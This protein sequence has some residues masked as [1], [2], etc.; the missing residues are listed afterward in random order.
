MSE[1]L[2]KNREHVALLQDIKIDKNLPKYKAIEQTAHESKEEDF[3][4]DGSLHPIIDSS[5]NFVSW[6][7]KREVDK[8][9]YEELVEFLS[10]KDFNIDEFTFFVEKTN[11]RLH[12][13]LFGI[14]NPL[15]SNMVSGNTDV[16]ISNSGNKSK[17]LHSFIE[18]IKKYFASTSRKK[19]EGD[20]FDVVG[21]FSAVKGITGEYNKEQ[22]VNRVKEYIECIGYAERNGQTALKEKLL[23]NLIVNKY[24]SVLF[25]NNYYQVLTE[26]VVVQLAKKS[27]KGLSL[28]YLQNYSRMIPIEAMRE[29]NEADKLHVFDNYCVMYYDPDGMVYLETAEERHKRKDP[30]LFGMIAGSNKLY[31]ICDWIDE[32]CD[33]TLEKVVEIVG[34]E[35]VESGYLKEK[36]IH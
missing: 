22:Y 5:E 18:K 34:K 25:V 29:K 10:N 4:P 28:T 31:Y 26:E 33:L 17:G 6:G 13:Q 2:T 16:L 21:F 36:I 30:I 23:S 1:L 14:T 12:D 24:E 19:E 3:D 35:V 11:K 20:E 7:I 15:F 8:P 32:Y 9:I 27:P